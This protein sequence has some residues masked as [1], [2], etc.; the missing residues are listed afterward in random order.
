[1]LKRNAACVI[2]AY[3]H[4]SGVCDPSPEDIALTRRLKETL[5]TIDVPLLDHII[6]TSTS[7]LSLAKVF[8]W[9]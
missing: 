4:P 9:N 7:Y 2:L 3:N 1:V 5:A 8:H 6:V